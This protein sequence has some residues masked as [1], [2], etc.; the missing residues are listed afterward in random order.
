MIAHAEQQFALGRQ[1]SD[2]CTRR[3]HLEAAAR[4]SGEILPELV[5]MP[6]PGGCAAIWSAFVELN[7]RRGSGAFGPL[8]ISLA[9]VD[10]WQRLMG[11]ALTPWEIETLFLLDSAAMA[12]QQDTMNHE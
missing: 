12:A 7:A 10:C 4:A 2:G 3:Q 9:D 5:P 1:Q 6:I 8:P 11:V